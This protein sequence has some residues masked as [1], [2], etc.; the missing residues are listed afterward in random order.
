MPRAYR[1][2]SAISVAAHL[3]GEAMQ[4]VQSA[5]TPNRFVSYG[6]LDRQLT[7]R[8]SWLTFW[9][10]FSFCTITMYNSIRV[11]PILTDIGAV[12]GMTLDDSGLIVSMFGIAGLVFAYPGAIFI[13]RF[14]IKSALVVAAI[15]SI[16]G[17]SLGLHRD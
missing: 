11:M 2:T 16:I 10:L 14:G 9:V 5:K 13:H 4:A 15:V 7:N 6:I 17:S 1:L 12:Y 3:M 8:E